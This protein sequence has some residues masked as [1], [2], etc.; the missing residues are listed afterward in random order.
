MRPVALDDVGHA[1]AQRDGERD[2][3][4]GAAQPE[5]TVEVHCAG[6]AE[7]E[8]RSGRS[9]E[10]DTARGEPRQCAD[11]AFSGCCGDEQGEAGPDG[12]GEQVD[13][14]LEDPGAVLLGE[15]RR[16]D[17]E[18]RAD[19]ALGEAG[20]GVLRGDRDE[21]VRG[22]REACHEAL[23]DRAARGERGGEGLGGQRRRD[24]EA[25]LGRARARA[26]PDVRGCLVCG[27][28]SLNHRGLVRGRG[29]TAGV[30]G[31]ETAGGRDVLGRRSPLPDPG[32]GLRLLR[33]MGD[34]NP[35]GR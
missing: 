8:R 16:A 9:G 13:G 30:V 28:V 27:H 33:R 7:V 6:V 12:D 18:G 25:G 32:R 2:T 31:V 29:G 10:R 15:P 35:R 1:C 26:A 24:E 17:Q 14:D 5:G 19:Q 22:D 23:V 21:I 20:E 3:R 34:S 4:E 11:R